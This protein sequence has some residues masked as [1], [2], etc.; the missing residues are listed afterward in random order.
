MFFRL[1]AFV[2]NKKNAKIR[3]KCQKGSFIGYS[4]E[5]KAIS[6]YDITEEELKKIYY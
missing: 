4:W 2:F 3:A 6:N 5:G 1:I